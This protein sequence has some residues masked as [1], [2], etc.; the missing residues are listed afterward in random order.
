VLGRFFDLEV[1]GAG[2]R[3]AC[4]RDQHDISKLAVG[5]LPAGLASRA[6]LRVVEH[7]SFR[8]LRSGYFQFGFCSII[9]FMPDWICFSFR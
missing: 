9:L 5:N 2:P 1:I 4:Q 7:P 8:D 6:A 3:N